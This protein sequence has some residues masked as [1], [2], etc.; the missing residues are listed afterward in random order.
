MGF[1][2]SVAGLAPGD[3]ATWVGALFAG[4]SLLAL[5]YNSI[6]DRTEIRKIHEREA[7]LRESEQARGLGG[8]IEFVPEAGVWR[9][10]V[11]NA[12]QLPLRQVKGYLLSLDP[13]IGDLTGG[14]MT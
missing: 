10:S 1:V 11:K 6:R 7:W 8:W 9:L 5:A 13:P 14:G 3:W 2:E 12:S 4:L